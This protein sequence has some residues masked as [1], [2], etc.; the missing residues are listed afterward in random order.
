M[1]K[2]TKS[3][4]FT[5]TLAALRPALLFL[6]ITLFIL[7]GAAV[8]FYYLRNHV[9]KQLAF[10]ADPPTVVLKDR[11]VWMSEALA[12]QIA[13]S[14]QPRVARSAMDHQLLK[15][16]AEVLQHNPWVRQVNHVRRIFTNAP[17]DTIE[18]DADFRA[19]LALV[20]HKNEYLLIDSEGYKLPQ[21]FPIAQNPPRVMFDDAGQ[22]TLRIIEGV[23]AL[24]PFRDGEPWIGQDL[25]AGLDMARLLYGKPFANEIHRI[26][27]ANFKGR[28][29]PREPQLVLIT[30]HRSEIRWGEPIKSTFSDVSPVT[31]LERLATIHQRFG[32]VDGTHSWLDI[33]FDKITYPLEESKLVQAAAN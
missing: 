8:G 10:P 28:R 1:A 5:S 20:P 3:A 2:K 13:A 6:F 15:D 29:S 26:N 32:R 4:T 7:G 16:V 11:P 21:R 25:Q 24:P 9:E 17:G 19:P 27:V 30:R 14:V 23:G 31:K 12:Q 18:I 33:R 22:L